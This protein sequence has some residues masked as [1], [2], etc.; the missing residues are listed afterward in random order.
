MINAFIGK[1]PGNE[2]EE[3]KDAAHIQVRAWE[4]QEMTAEFISSL[5]LKPKLPQLL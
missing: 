4:N 2:M 3:E 5:P 1:A